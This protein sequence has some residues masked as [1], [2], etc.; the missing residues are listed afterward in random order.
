MLTYIPKSHWHHICREAYRVLRPDGTVMFMEATI[1]PGRSTPEMNCL[2]DSLK[3]AFERAG[4]AS[5][6]SKE[7]DAILEA[8]KFT[9]INQRHIDIP[10][11]EQEDIVSRLMRQQVANLFE[12]ARDVFVNSTSESET[13][14]QLL[15]NLHEHLSQAN[16]YVRIYIYTARKPP[17]NS[18]DIARRQRSSSKLPTPQRSTND[19]GKIVDKDRLYLN[20]SNIHLSLDPESYQN[21]LD[22]DNGT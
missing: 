19:L 1:L 8:A 3:E 21:A 20:L 2:H 13:Y 6:V 9:D 16:A 14:N 10:V 11:S 5:D 4:I 18:K 17:K 22:D 12:M 7:L 15:D